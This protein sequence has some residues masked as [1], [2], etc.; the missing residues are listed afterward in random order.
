MTLYRDDSLKNLP[1]IHRGQGVRC[2]VRDTSIVPKDWKSFLRHSENKTELFVL[3][4]RIYHA[5]LKPESKTV[6]ITIHDHVL[7]WPNQDTSNIDPCNHEEA[8]TRIFTHIADARHSQQMTR[9]VI[10]TVDTGVVVHA[11]FAVARLEEQQFG[12]A[13]GS[14]QNLRFIDTN[15]I[16]VLLGR[17][18]A[19]VFT[20]SHAITGCDNVF[21]Q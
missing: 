15:G 19:R 10:Y 12:V 1:R 6:I 21:L 4:A 3:I 9:I 14:Q 17:Q 7:C 5:N 13:F 16:F 18:K 8:D 20:M 2:R 11:V